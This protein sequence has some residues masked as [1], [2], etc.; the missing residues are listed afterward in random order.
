MSEDSFFKKALSDPEIIDGMWYHMERWLDRMYKSPIE[1][2]YGEMKT[3]M[4]ENIVKAVQKYE[5]LVD[6]EE[7]IKALNYDRQQYEKGFNDCMK[8]YEGGCT[9]CAFEDKEMWEMPCMKCKRNS[10]DYWRMKGVKE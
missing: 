7:L 3:E 1:I 5:I 6:E 4:G 8:Q 10:V 9:D 2:I